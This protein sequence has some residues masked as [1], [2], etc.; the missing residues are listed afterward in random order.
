MKICTPHLPPVLPRRPGDVEASK[1]CTCEPDATWAGTSNRFRTSNTV[2][3][4]LHFGANLKTSGI[5][6]FPHTHRRQNPP[7]LIPPLQ[8]HT[9]HAYL[10]PRHSSATVGKYTR[11]V[12]RSFTLEGSN[13]IQPRLMYAAV[14]PRP[15]SRQT[16][17]NVPDGPRKPLIPWYDHPPP[18][19]VVS[20][21]F[22]M[23]PVLTPARV[24]GTSS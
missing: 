1:T 11:P 14:R 15:S 23:F 20:F 9:K 16:S 12:S 5:T 6:M 24:R 7:L 4:P 19:L 17:E 10:S 18:D 3:L 8:E 13:I 21:T 2:S 22:L